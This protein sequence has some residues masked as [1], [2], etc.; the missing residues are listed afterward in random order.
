MMKTISLMRAV[1]LALLAGCSAVPESGKRTDDIARV[2]QMG[3]ADKLY[4]VDCLLPGQIQR[5]GQS[6]T[7]LM[8][9]RPIKAT[10]VDCEIRGGEYVAYD[11]ANYATSLKIWLPKAQ[12]GDPE[13][14][15]YTGEIYEKGL[16]TQPDYK[17]AADW[18]RKA[19]AQGNSRAQINLGN[20][21]EKGLG[22]EKNL[23]TA[24]E[25][26][27]KASG[28]EK[29]DLP[30]AATI[31]TSSASSS[32]TQNPVIEI[33]DP[34]LVVQRETLP[35]VTLRSLVKERKIIGRADS[36]AGIISVMVNNNKNTLDHGIFKATVGIKGEKTPVKVVAVD[37]NGALASLE[38]L[39]LL[40]SSATSNPTDQEPRE[41][42][43]RESMERY[44]LWQLLC[45]DHR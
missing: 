38:F 7:I 40:E 15:A 9:R 11:R 20:L 16:G 29:K 39:L 6:M 34:P 8:P 12:S 13:A 24:M 31:A 5:L 17:T 18:Y 27:R 21:Y 32:I 37:Q 42:I 28:L 44:R 43:S 3:D 1:S 30:Y 19:S 14:Q 2:E 45:I 41:S 10:A 22:V 25:W 33:I 23:S 35:T 36:P 26:Y 4:I